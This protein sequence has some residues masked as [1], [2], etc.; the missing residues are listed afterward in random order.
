MHYRN[1]AADAGIDRTTVI[2]I[3][4]DAGDGASP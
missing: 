3:A 2:E 1:C 4:Y